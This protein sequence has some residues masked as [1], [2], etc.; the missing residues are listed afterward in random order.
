MHFTITSGANGREVIDQ[1]GDASSAYK[2][3]LDLVSAKRPN[4]RILDQDG[5]L[6]SLEKLHCLADKEG[7]ERQQTKDETAT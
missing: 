6:V 3:V 5:H 7:V 4:V 1:R 2:R